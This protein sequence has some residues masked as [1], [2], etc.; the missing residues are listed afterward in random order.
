VLLLAAGGTAAGQRTPA[1]EHVATSPNGSIRVVI[2]TTPRLAWAVHHD[3]A[4]VLLESPIAL[5]LAD[6]RILGEAGSSIE[7]K[8]A[9]GA[10]WVARLEPQ[11]TRQ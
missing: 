5:T 11:T 6:G 8:L 4:A 2:T 10:G 7:V 9:P 3:G 1:V